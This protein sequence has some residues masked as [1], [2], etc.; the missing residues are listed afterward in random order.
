MGI[1]VIW[2]HL[3]QAA[4]RARAAREA[5]PDLVIPTMPDH[6]G[7]S[8]GGA[9]NAWIAEW[10]DYLYEARTV[11]GDLG[12]MLAETATAYESADDEVAAAVATF[13]SDLGTAL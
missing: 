3:R 10:S 5:A 6:G 11:V 7:D 1:D 13:D 9:A 8:V 2:D 12:D 4:E